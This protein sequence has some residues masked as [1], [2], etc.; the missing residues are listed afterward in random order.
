VRKSH[1]S[2]ICTVLM[3]SSCG[4]PN[5]VSIP[6]DISKKGATEQ[7]F[8]LY[9]KYKNVVEIAFSRE[10]VSFEKIRELVGSSGV[11][12]P[13]QGSCPHGVVIP[14]TWS[15]LDTNG[16]IV[17]TNSISSVEAHGWS[18]EYVFRNIGEFSSEPG[19][20]LL[21]V[22][23]SKDTPEFKGIKA[24]IAIHGPNK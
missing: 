6:I 7:S 16:N 11:C 9:G 3:L 1:I 5:D 18:K 22:E 10:F 17:A 19:E 12:P 8:E 2:I 24:H 20:Y 4:K 14:I 15:I 13:N 21:K 23:L